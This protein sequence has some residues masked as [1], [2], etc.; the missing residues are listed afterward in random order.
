MTVSKSTVE[1]KK[2]TPAEYRSCEMLIF[3][4]ISILCRVSVRVRHY[5]LL[6]LVPIVHIH[7][8]CFY[9]CSY[10]QLFPLYVITHFS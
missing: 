7:L 6:E 1:D 3:L 2:T 10:A 5:L 8:T 9:K 4:I